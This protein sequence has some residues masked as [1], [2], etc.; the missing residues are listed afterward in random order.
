MIQDAELI[1]DRRRLR[2]RLSVW[3]IVAVLALVAGVAAI[4]LA[5]AG[6][7]AS[8]REPHVA[9]I[10][11]SGFIAGD[12][13]TL[14]LLDSVRESSRAQAVIVAIDSPGGTTTGAE[15]LYEKLRRLAATKPTIAMVDGLAASGGYIV[16]LGADRIVARETSLVGSIGV[17]MQ[18]PN[19]GGLLD[20]VGVRVEEVK[21]SPLKAAPNGFE[22]T[23]PE[24]RAAIESIV[25]DS[26]DW[27][28]GLVRERRGYDAQ[29]VAAVADGRVHTGRQALRLRLVDELGSEREALAWLRNERKIGSELPVREWKPKRESDTFSLWSSLGTVA[30]GLGAQNA[31]ALLRAL[32]GSESQRSLDGLL[33][34]WQPA[35][36]K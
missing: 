12:A 2:R 29:G 9:R 11:I 35:L 27:F 3:R 26:Y 7:F 8:L 13:A 1:A 20:K 5:L 17:L 36:E 25:A 18:I 30:D 31:A 32:G 10:N 4:G 24:A 14:K 19:V 23:S 16:A 34:V 28:K 22:P 21:S 15:A 33:A 6:P